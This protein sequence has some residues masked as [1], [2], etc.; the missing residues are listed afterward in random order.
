MSLLEHDRLV[1]AERHLTE[2]T[3]DLRASNA[4]LEN[5]NQ[6]LLAATERANE[7]AR[8]AQVASQ[9]KSDFL[10][11]MSHEIRTPMNGVIG[12][13]ELLLGHAA[14]MREQR[15]HAETIRDSARRAAD[16]SSTTCSTS[17]R[18]KRASSTWSVI[19][20]DLARRCI[21]DVDAPDRRR[22]ARERARRSRPTIDRRGAG[23]SCAAIRGG[24]GRC[25]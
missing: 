6:R 9:A 10:A 16:A 20:F 12:M 19:E 14:R 13:T 15:E 4:T 8:I 11:N 22:R 5:T 25:W 21:E 24:C 1:A 23:A 18:S 3:H 2:R 7:M 17:R